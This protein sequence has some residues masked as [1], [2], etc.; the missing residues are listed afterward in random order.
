MQTPFCHTTSE[1]AYKNEGKV[2]VPQLV[3]ML[4]GIASGMKY[5]TEMSYIHKCLAAIKS[6]STQT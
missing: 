1:L 4:T 3:G 6:S 5:L 2:S